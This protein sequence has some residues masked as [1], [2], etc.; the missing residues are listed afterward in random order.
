[1]Q[2][3][4]LVLTLTGALA[5]F[6]GSYS[7]ATVP[8]FAGTLLVALSNARHT[9][10]F[11]R[12]HRWLDLALAAT[13]GAIALQLIPLPRALVSAL[14]PRAATVRGTLRLDAALADGW[15][16]VSIDP[17]ATLEALLVFAS[18]VLVFWSARAAFAGGGL[19]RFCRAIAVIGVVLSI[20]AM[21]QRVAT[22]LLIYGFWPPYTPN[23][24]PF[25]PFFNRNHFAAW[26]MMAIPL[27]A[28]YLAARVRTRTADARE[29]LGVLRIFAVA[30]AP[31]AIVLAM[32]LL[33]IAAA[34]SRSAIVGLAAAA[35]AAKFL[36]RNKRDTAP[37]RTGPV[38]VVI[39]LGAMFLLTT[40]DI[41]QWFQRINSMMSQTDTSRLTIWRET[42]PVIRD[43]WLTGPGAGTYSM[44][45][46]LYQ[47]SVIPMPHLRNFAHFNQAHSHYVQVAAEGGL[48]LSVP[49]LVAG[50]AFVR[51]ARAA[52]QRDRGEAMWIR[53]GAT[54][55]LAAI[56]TQSIW[57]TALRMPANALLCA[58]LA[59]AVVYRRETRVDVHE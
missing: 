27:V 35:V 32:M 37:G 58:A 52:L 28:G 38:L 12:S 5:A 8:I 13:A 4:L 43:F 15:I 7:W 17:R 31:L 18:A 20:G 41:E 47:Q 10:H 1:M 40:V 9:F 25:G 56:A 46:L 22:P 16:P 30:G 50:V 45:M 33:A 49:L 26:I 6:G 39:A 14:S 19:R 24:Q 2:R 29:P 59:G 53:I 48:L 42:L 21:I 54:A 57:E 34:L 3:W 55:S 51:S 44:V 11:P 23:A 36:G